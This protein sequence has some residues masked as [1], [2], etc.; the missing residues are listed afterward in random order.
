MSTRLPLQGQPNIGPAIARDLQ[1]LGIDSLES[2]ASQ[3]A[4]QMY[5]KLC[6]LTASRQDPCVLDTFLAI[7]HNAKTGEHRMW[8]TFTDYRKSSG[9]LKRIAK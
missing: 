6:D 8:W 9:L 2:L 7:V 4:L 1:L 3:S 5:E